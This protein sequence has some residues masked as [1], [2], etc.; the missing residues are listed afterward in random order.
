MQASARIVAEPDGRGGTRL[1][2]LSGQP[3]LLARRTGPTEVHLVGGAAG[4]LGGDDLTVRIE[5]RA[6]A[7]LTVRTV[8]ATLALPGPGGARSR[9]RVFAHVA[10]G[11]SL[12][13]RPEP[14]V[15][16]AGCDHTMESTVELDAG[17]RLLWREELV[18]GRHGEAGGDLRLHTA[19]TLDGV[20]LLRQAL[21]VGPAAPG[22]SGPAVLGGARTAGSL[23]LV[24]PEAPTEPRGPAVLR[25][26]DAYAARVTLA[27]G[28]GATLVTATA[29]D[30]RALRAAL[31][32]LADHETTAPRG[33]PPP[34][35]APRPRRRRDRS[36]RAA[37][38]PPTRHR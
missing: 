2:E 20:A 8:A 35:A 28:A 34:P 37:P 3:P 38:A 18:C 31:Q 22:W 11:A 15:A 21:A 14:I 1:V 16:V 7:T 4:P 24:D 12:S 27:A 5:V 9:T 13:W 30:A 17:A 33:P 6:G 23:L 25:R 32:S 19:A 29:D 36:R 10:A 26:P